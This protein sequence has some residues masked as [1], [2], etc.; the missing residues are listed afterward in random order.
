MKE[1]FLSNDEQ[2]QRKLEEMTKVVG[3]MRWVLNIEKLDPQRDSTRVRST[4]DVGSGESQKQTVPAEATESGHARKL[5]T[6]SKARRMMDDFMP[7]SPS[8][9]KK[10]AKR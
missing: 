10:K 5:S 2:L 1:N 3:R 8:K 7:S 9:S 4:S 6:P